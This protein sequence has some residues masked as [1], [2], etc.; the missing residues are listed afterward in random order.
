MIFPFLNSRINE[1]L[2][3]HGCLILFDHEPDAAKLFHDAGHGHGGALAALSSLDPDV[4]MAL[5]Q[6][7][8]PPTDHSLRPMKHWRAP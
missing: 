5:Q 4:K 2:P 8:P 3:S 6:Y 1:G 7:G